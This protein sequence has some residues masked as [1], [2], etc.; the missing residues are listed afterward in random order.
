MT[1]SMIDGIVGARRDRRPHGPDRGERRGR[2]RGVRAGGPGRRQV[3]VRTVRSAISPG[4][5][6]TFFGKDATNVYLHKRWNEEL[7]L[8]EAGTPSMEYP[9]VFGYRAAGE[10]VESRDPTT[11]RRS[12]RVRQLAP[13]RVQRRCPGESPRTSVLPGRPD[14][15]RRGRH[16]RRW[17]RSAS[18][19]SRSGRAS[20]S[21]RRSSSSVPAP[22]GLITA[23]VARADGRRS[24]LR[25][26]PDPERLAIAA[27][28]GLEPVE[29]ADGRRRGAE[30]QAAPRHRRAS[31]SPGSA[32]ARHVALHEAIRVVRRRGIVV[33]VGFYQG[34][35]A[36]CCSATS[37]TT[38]ASA[39]CAARSATSTRRR[40][41]RHCAPGSIEL[42]RAGGHARRAAAADPAGRACGRRLRGAQAPG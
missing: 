26:R 12:P 30:P 39:S 33:A 36:A 8:F 28:L 22:V 6:M 37:S 4:T 11:C 24:R 25:R 1:V 40:L 23:Q 29:A 17:A 16:R 13:H 38:T 2:V 35:G 10:V 7:R 15:G 21:V 32:P 34:E 19:P 31:R 42:A 5:E 9:I 14:L 3:R 20:T 41:G 18:T 27:I